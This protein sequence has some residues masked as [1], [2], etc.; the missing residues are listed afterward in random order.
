MARKHVC[1]C[2]WEWDGWRTYW[3]DYCRTQLNHLNCPPPSTFPTHPITPFSVFIL[4]LSFFSNI[5]RDN[6]SCSWVLSSFFFSFSLFPFLYLSPSFLHKT[7]FSTVL[8]FFP[9]YP[10]PSLPACLFSKCTYCPCF[11]SLPSSLTPEQSSAV[12]R[13]DPFTQGKKRKRLCYQQRRVN[14]LYFNMGRNLILFEDCLFFLFLFFSHSGFKCCKKHKLPS[15][16]QDL[17]PKRNYYYVV[18]FFYF[19]FHN[20]SFLNDFL[21][22]PSW[23][24]LHRLLSKI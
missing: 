19:F 3:Q 21:N 16:C 23:F 7:T 15:V 2:F 24:E 1:D 10:P 11:P 14:A 8:F 17:H 20:L 22:R 18:G 12:S 6:S 9:S 13:Q 5:E 4:F